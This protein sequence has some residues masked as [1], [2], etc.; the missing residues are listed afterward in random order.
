MYPELSQHIP[1]TAHLTKLL[2]YSSRILRTPMRHASLEFTSCHVDLL[3][4]TNLIVRM[5]S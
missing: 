1:I 4:T 5:G 3:T 2:D